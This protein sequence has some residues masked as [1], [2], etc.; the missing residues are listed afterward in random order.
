[1]N[2]VPGF[3]EDIFEIIATALGFSSP[4]VLD[5]DGDGIELT[6]LASAD[7]VYWD[8]DLDGFA[9]ASG[10][11]TGGDGLLAI[12]LNEDGI[13]N[14]SG[15]LFGDQTGAANGFVALAAYDSNQDG[16]ITA[17]DVAFND[18]RV[19]IDDS[20]DGYSQA[21]E[22][23]T[24]SSL[25]ITS[26]SLGYSDVNYAI[27]GNNVLQ[28]STFTINGNA[29]DIVDAYFAFSD[30]NTV[31]NQDFIF[32]IRALFMP[33]LRGYGEVAA[34]HI[35]MSLDNEGTGNLLELVT[36]LN[37]SSFT[38]LFTSTS[39]TPD[40]V[41]DIMYRWAG[42]EGVSPTA[43]GYEIDG[44]DLAFLEALM[45]QPFLQG[46]SNPNPAGPEAGESL[47][48]AFSIAFNHVYA[49][50]LAQSAG[51]ELFE[52]DWFYNI[53][54]DSF[55]GIT[56]LNS[57]ALGL[58]E[59]EATGL[60]NTGLRQSFW[61]NVVRVIEYAVGTDNLDGGDLTALQTA[62]TDSDVTLDL[63]D[64]IL[65]ALVYERISGVSEGG[66]SG[67]ETMNGS[68]GP[69]ANRPRARVKK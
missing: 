52:G 66:T 19:W 45:G 8:L 44:R 59:T 46:G 24:M 57:T 6:S 27:S 10:W 18:L 51:G 14:D 33:T 39:D 58:L 49:R 53:A 37:A 28:E 67:A 65:P 5:I 2:L 30:T 9:E 3:I 47:K 48:E 64:D 50:L 25:L 13:I 7:A 1:M 68:S 38:D 62:I 41:L 15:E 23:H 20:M 35:A 32:D 34:L 40:L 61:E 29:R 63:E 4:L 56:G 21:D 60:A 36:D 54:T 17:E 55:E 42:V 31:H 26:I 22:L 12:D 43:R 11:V 69:R 16:F